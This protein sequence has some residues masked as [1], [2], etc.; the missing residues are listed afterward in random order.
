[1]IVFVILCRQVSRYIETNEPK[2]IRLQHILSKG[3]ISQ[4]KI[5]PK[6]A[7]RCWSATL[8]DGLSVVSVKGAKPKEAMLVATAGGAL[9]KPSNQV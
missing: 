4:K 7:L 3:I 8:F 6:L 1:M 2:E 9:G 5:V